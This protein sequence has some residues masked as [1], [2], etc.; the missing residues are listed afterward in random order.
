MKPTIL[1]RWS[2]SSRAHSDNRTTAA[3]IIRAHRL[4]RAHTFVRYDRTTHRIEVGSV[5]CPE[6]FG[7]WTRL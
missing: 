1:F 6:L 2:D 7:I 3:R 4:N 5:F